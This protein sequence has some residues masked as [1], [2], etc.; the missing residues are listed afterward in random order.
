MPQKRTDRSLPGDFA[1]PEKKED[2]AVTPPGPHEISKKIEACTLAD[3]LS[4]LTGI[5]SLPQ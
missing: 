1:V 3:F 4:L 2:P 5:S